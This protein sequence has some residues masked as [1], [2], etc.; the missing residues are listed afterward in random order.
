MTT[1]AQIQKK[2]EGGTNKGDAIRDLDARVVVL[3][4]SPTVAPGSIGATQLG[5][6]AVTTPK[7]GPG[8]VTGAKMAPTGVTSG[9][10][11]G[12]NG[13]GA[14]TLTGAV[15]GQRVLAL[16]EIDT[17]SGTVGEQAKFESVITVND[18]IQ[19]TDVGN[20]S[21]KKYAVILLPAAA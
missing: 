4:G 2:V 6:A 14:C 15:I 17:N 3:E 18:Q 9:S 5:A 12:K 13:A 10:F 20:L 21:A 1:S 16:F 19:Q 7:L 11:L 8:A